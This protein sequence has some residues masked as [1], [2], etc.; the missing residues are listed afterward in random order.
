MCLTF[1][2]IFVKI[3]TLK[4]AMQ[5]QTQKKVTIHAISTTSILIISAR[6]LT[7]KTC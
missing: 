7:D 4:N 5:T 1:I 2:H 3:A 6:T